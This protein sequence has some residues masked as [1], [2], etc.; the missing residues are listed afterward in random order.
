LAK[1]SHGK[2]SETL[3]ST[4]SV[5]NNKNIKIWSWVALCICIVAS[6]VLIGRVAWLQ[7]VRGDELSKAAKA[8]QNSGRTITASR[9]TIYDSNGT[10]LA[11]SISANKVT[12]SRNIINS[13]GDK[14]DGG[15]EAYQKMIAKDLSELLSLDYDKLLEKL[16]GSGNYLEIASKLDIE[17]GEKVSEWKS[18][19]KIKGIYVD[20]DTKRYYPNGELASH[21]IGFTGKDGDGLV[22]GVEVALNDVLKGTNG[23]IITAVDAL[24][25]EVPTDEISRIDPVNGYNVT[26]TLD[27]T[28][29]YMVEEALSDAS[30]DFGVEEGCC[31]IV[32]DPDTGDILAMASNPGFDLNAPYDCPDGMDPSTWINGSA[33]SVEILNSTV[34][35]NKAL[36]DT[37]EPGSTFKT[38]TACM[39]L[40]EGVVTPETEF[41]DA[42]VDLSGWTIHCWHRAGHGTETFAKAIMN[43]CNP[44]MVRASQ[45]LG[46]NTFYSYVASFGFTEKT[47]IML[48]GEANSV[49]HT[50]PTE[51]DMAVA[52][53][54][55]RL[56]ITPLQLVSAYSAVANGGY[57]YEPR[58]VKE[59]T[60]ENGNVIKRY[61]TETVRQVISNDTSEKVLK[62]LEDTVAKGGGSRAYVS[63][64][65]VAGKTGTSETTTTDQT[66]RYVCS[67][68]GIAP[69]DDPE[70]VIL[71]VV[72][73]PTIGGASGGV[74][75]AS[76]VGRLFQEILDYLEIE[77]RYTEDDLKNLL[78]SYDVPSFTSGT[79]A[80]ATYTINLSTFNYVIVG[81]KT[82]D[83]KIV[84]QFPAPG[85]KVARESTI[86]LYTDLESNISQ[87]RMPDLKGLSLEDAHAT[88]VGMGLNMRA[89]SL[90]TVVGQS[91]E[92]GTYIDK[93]SVVELSVIDEESAN[94]GNDTVVEN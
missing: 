63:G 27:A 47:G 45:K 81:P 53:F 59:I 34:W 49:I 28:I 46:I 36:T 90:G 32:M 57:L 87:V 44:I 3:L 74:Q 7:F 80:D 18:A 82:D 55:Q 77:K 9:G 16:K 50:N 41:S 5:E 69:A 76:I 85:V 14:Y 65:R 71:A 26:L 72:D 70:V 62:M 6:V 73:H 23:K 78:S 20:S 83:A 94:A 31:C 43:S 91:I 93:G 58:I 19:N 60:D 17:V 10:V 29:Q 33:E 12:A 67:F 64:Y 88:L 48:S 84:A 13:T 54:G 38:I 66:G 37:Y 39:S 89:F 92:A 22:C 75:A 42:P 30:I 56:Q 8:Q 52:S 51:I 68:A 4:K 25:H 24:G 21:V 11:V 79:V 15:R 35:R 1:R 86:V 40:E 61:E 2:I